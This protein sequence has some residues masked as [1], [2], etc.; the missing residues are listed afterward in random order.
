MTRTVCPDDGFT[1]LVTQASGVLPIGRVRPFLA[2]RDISGNRATLCCSRPVRL[3]GAQLGMLALDAVFARA[4][5]VALH[6]AL[7]TGPTSGA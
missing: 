7:P 6:L 3:V 1:C 5:V 2:G 4:S